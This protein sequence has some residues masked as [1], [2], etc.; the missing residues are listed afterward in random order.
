MMPHPVRAITPKAPRRMA[1]TVHR[2]HQRMP[3]HTTM[4][5]MSRVVGRM[6]PPLV[7]LSCRRLHQMVR[8][9][10]RRD[11]QTLVGRPR[12]SLGLLPG[13]TTG[14]TPVPLGGRTGRHRPSP[15][16]SRKRI[17]GRARIPRARG[18]PTLPRDRNRPRRRS[19]TAA[20]ISSRP[21]R[22]PTRI[23]ISSRPVQG[24]RTAAQISSRPPRRPTRGQVSSLQGSRTAAQICS[25]PQR[26]PTRAQISSRPPRRPTRGQV[27][28]R[29]VQGSRTAAQISSRLLQRS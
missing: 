26:C 10:T 13:P 3:I 8:L 9:S 18:H 16:P 11:R 19:R 25:R 12:R 15:A 22:S 20:Q 21:P 24:S 14:P 7:I 28:C 4:D 29:P 17:V 27:S 5:R 2:A 1:R 6:T 23:Q